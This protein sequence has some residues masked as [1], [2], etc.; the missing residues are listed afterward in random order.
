MAR[1][2]AWFL[3]H[4]ATI[5]CAVY[6]TDVLVN[7]TLVFVS[8]HPS[9]C[10]KL[11]H[12]RNTTDMENYQVFQVFKALASRMKETVGVYAYDVYMETQKDSLE[13]D[14]ARHNCLNPAK[15][16]IGEPFSK[17]DFTK[18]TKSVAMDNGFWFII[19][20][21]S[22]SEFFED[23]K[24]PFN[25]ELIVAKIKSR[26]RIEF[27]EVYRV[28]ENYPRRI[29]NYGVWTIEEGLLLNKQRLYARRSDLEGKLIRAGYIEN[30][31]MS[32][33]R[34]GLWDGFFPRIWKEIEAQINCT[35]QPYRSVDNATG[36]LKTNGSWN[37]L[38][39]MLLRGEIDVI[40]SETT[41]DYDRS[42]VLKFS[43]PILISNYQVF[44]C[45][46][47]SDLKWTAVLYPFS[48]S[49]WMAV[50]S[51]LIAG[52]LTISICHHLARKRIPSYIN[53]EED[54][55]TP[56]V[57][58]FFILQSLCQQG[59]PTVPRLASGKIIFLTSYL[60][61][62]VLIPSYSAWLIYSLTHHVPNK[63]FNSF[64][65]FL[66][67]GRYELNIIKHSAEQTYFKRSMNT[68]HRMVY[69]T[70]KKN[71][72]RVQ[73]VKEGLE[74]TFCQ[75][76]QQAFF[77]VEAIVKMYLQQSTL[78]SCCHIVTFSKPLSPVYQSLGFLKDYPYSQLINYKLQRLFTTGV[79]DNI[80]KHFH[81]K[82]HMAQS[83]KEVEVG[84]KDVFQI[85]I[86]LLLGLESRRKVAGSWELLAGGDGGGGRTYQRRWKGPNSE[87]SILWK[88]LRDCSPLVVN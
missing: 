77:G 64:E 28:D 6:E 21:S 87:N 12:N 7:L 69:A 63:P 68:L 34:N 14:Q 76:G 16:V 26:D 15:Y 80:Q 84:I 32:S 56:V 20:N 88:D 33:L 22:V 18:L 36:V 11:I 79:I 78:H 72:Q 3:W 35:T 23:A 31:P 70:V 53:K 19:L 39:G 55:F 25:S 66:S 38:V 8:Y 41:M 9:N 24:T 65:E 58:F 74:R 86:L 13:G 57:S 54:G 52:T 59:Y 49:T 30:W 17:N 43:R 81:Y 75:M 27:R 61:S 42:T 85:F 4:F 62:A 10:I 73:S 2:V 40:V 5:A 71:K 67:L 60:L 83:Y 46:L 37:G 51:W 1:L 82:R 45:A 50:C 48:R 29:Y 47:A 44:F